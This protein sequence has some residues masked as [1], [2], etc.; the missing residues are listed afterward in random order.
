MKVSSTVLKTSTPGDRRTEFIALA[1]EAVLGPRPRL[2]ASAKCC[3]LAPW[4]GFRERPW[5]GAPFFF[6]FHAN[7]RSAQS[8]SLSRLDDPW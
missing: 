5:F 8:A 4:S 7:Y 1:S 3:S 6:G 2:G